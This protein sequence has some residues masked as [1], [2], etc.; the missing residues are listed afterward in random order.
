MRVAAAMV[1]AMMAAVALAT[2][3]VSAPKPAIPI[4]IIID[5]VGDR[6][7]DGERVVN[8]PGQVT[9]GIL[10]YTP[11]AIRLSELAKQKQKEVVLH[12][13]MEALEDRYLGKGGLDSHMDKAKFMATLK[14]SLQAVPYIRGVNNHMG[15]RLTQDKQRMGWLMSGLYE[16]G[17][18]YFL[19]SRTIDTSQAY[20]AAVQMGL[21]HATR[22]V[23]FR[24]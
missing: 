23:F 12:L 19:D 18:L 20:D 22:D 3:P 15:S 16:H 2:E 4:A 14:Q 6:L 24:S 17:N 9:I 11:F 5:D 10:P 7:R 8:L 1:L 13:P 21:A